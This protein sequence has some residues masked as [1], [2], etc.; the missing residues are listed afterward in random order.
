MAGKQS[1]RLAL[2]ETVPLFS[3]M[4][5]KDLRALAKLAKPMTLEAYT[6]LVTQGEKG[7]ACFVLIDG[8]AAVHRNGRKIAELGPGSV[9]GEMALLDG[10]ERSATVTMLGR[11]EVLR[12][13]KKGFDRLLA[14]S[15]D[16]SRAL[17]QRMADKIRELD[18]KMYG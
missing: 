5:K 18:R 7:D 3:T 12:I 4:R 9:I 8:T 1:Q 11:G 10:H 17:M 2:V 14:S 15:P 13:Q 16:V 6:R